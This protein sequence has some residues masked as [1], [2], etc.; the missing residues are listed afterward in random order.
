MSILIFKLPS[1]VLAFPDT[2]VPVNSDFSRTESPSVSKLGGAGAARP[3]DEK[4]TRFYQN[5]VCRY[6]YCGTS[7][8]AQIASEPEPRIWTVEYLEIS[9]CL[10]AT[11]CSHIFSLLFPILCRLSVKQPYILGRRTRRIRS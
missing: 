3:V 5:A 11:V 1:G 2:A 4:S 10:V 9:A 8:L 7:P 6:P